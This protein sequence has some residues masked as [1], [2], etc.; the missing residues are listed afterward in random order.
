[1]PETVVTLDTHDPLH[2][3]MAFGSTKGPPALSMAVM[4]RMMELVRQVADMADART[5]TITGPDTVMLAGGDLKSF[6]ALDTRDKGRAM[7]VKMRSVIDG[8]QALPVPVIAAISGNLFGGGMELAVGCDVRIAASHVRMGFTQARFGLIPGWGGAS[9]LAAL[10]GPGRA[11]YL[12]S[13]ARMVDAK[14]ALH[15]GLV[16]VVADSVDLPGVLDDYRSSVARLSPAAVASLKRVIRAG[17]AGTWAANLDYE[18][19]EFTALWAA[20]E[21]Q[22]GLRAFFAKEAPKWQ[23]KSE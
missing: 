2:P 5:L 3:C 23:N 17:M 21:H 19:D 10:I 8:L 12:M 4:D 1:M 6:L 16:D 11:F 7:A 22:E 13:S 18:L 15:I 9:R 14:T 20:P